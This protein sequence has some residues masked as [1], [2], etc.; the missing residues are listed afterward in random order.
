MTNNSVV[1]IQNMVKR[2]PV[3]GDFFTALKNVNLNID[4]A[5]FTGLVGPSGSGKTTLLNIIGGLDS[6]SEGEVNSLGM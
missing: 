6:P 4:K 3:G 5:E 1:E 2:F